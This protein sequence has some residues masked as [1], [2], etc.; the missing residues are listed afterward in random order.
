[1]KEI[2]K[3]RFLRDCIF[4]ICTKGFGM[5]RI[6]AFL[7][8]VFCLSLVAAESEADEHINVIIAIDES[9]SMDW[10]DPNGHRFTALQEFMYVGKA[11]GAFPIRIGV[12]PFAEDVFPGEAVLQPV[13]PA[14]IEVQSVVDKIKTGSKSMKR[15]WTHFPTAMKRAFR[16]FEAYPYDYN[17]LIVLSD[18]ID[19]CYCEKMYSEL[20]KNECGRYQEE[21]E[22]NN[23]LIPGT[24]LEEAI[25]FFRGNK[26][27]F[28]SVNINME[29][30]YAPGEAKLTAQKRKEMKVGRKL[31]ERISEETGGEFRP[32]GNP[33]VDA[34]GSLKAV[35]RIFEEFIGIIGSEENVPIE[36]VGMGDDNGFRIELKHGTVVAISPDLYYVQTADGNMFDVK[37]LQR[38]VTV[39]LDHVKATRHPLENQDEEIYI[40]NRPSNLSGEKNAQAENQWANSRGWKFLDRN[41]RAIPERLVQIKA[42]SNLKIKNLMRDDYKI[43]DCPVIKYDVSDVISPESVSESFWQEIRSRA[44]AKGAI[45]KS[46]EPP[47]QGDPA[48]L[49]LSFRNNEIYGQLGEFKQLGNYYAHVQLYLKG[50]NEIV[51]ASG[52]R[53]RL[54][55]ED[56]DQKVIV[57][58]VLLKDRRGR[59]TETPDSLR[60]VIPGENLEVRF[61]KPSGISNLK[62]DVKG[63]KVGKNNLKEISG[64]GKTQEGVID[65]QVEEKGE[66]LELKMEYERK[67]PD[68]EI[69]KGKATVFE[70][71]NRGGPSLLRM[72]MEWK[73]RSPVSLMVGEASRFELSVEMEGGLLADRQWVDTNPPSI[74]VESADGFE[75]GHCRYDKSEKAEGKALRYGLYVVGSC[76]EDLGPGSYRLVPN[77]DD[78]VM[79][80]IGMRGGFPPILDVTLEPPPFD[81]FFVL[82]EDGDGNKV[83]QRLPLAQDE[84]FETAGR[85]K[86]VLASK[87]ECGGSLPEALELFYG[88]AE[89]FFDTRLADRRERTDVLKFTK[90][91]GKNEW[92]TEPFGFKRAGN[93]QIGLAFKDETGRTRNVVLSGGF[94]TRTPPSCLARVLENEF[95]IGGGFTLPIELEIRGGVASDLPNV[96]SEIRTTLKSS[97]FSIQSEENFSRVI[98]SGSEPVF[99]KTENRFQIR[100]SE[101]PDKPGK[102]NLVV[103]FPEEGVLDWIAAFDIEDGKISFDYPEPPYWLIAA[104]GTLIV[105]LLLVLVHL[106]A[107]RDFPK[108][109]VRV[110]NPAKTDWHPLFPSFYKRMEG[111]VCI[112]G[113]TVIDI[114]Y[115]KQLRGIYKDGVKNIGQPDLVKKEGLKSVLRLNEKPELV[116]K[117]EKRFVVACLSIAI[118]LCVFAIGMFF[119]HCVIFPLMFALAALGLTI[120]VG[121]AIYQLPFSLATRKAFYPLGFLC[122]DIGSGQ[123]IDEGRLELAHGTPK[124]VNSISDRDRTKP[125]SSP[126]GKDMSA[127]P[128]GNARTRNGGTMDNACRQTC[129]WAKSD[130]ESLLTTAYRCRYQE[131]APEKSCAPPVE[132]GGGTWKIVAGYR[133][134]YNNPRIKTDSGNF[135]MQFR[136]SDDGEQSSQEKKSNQR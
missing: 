82:I 84:T 3:A 111:A 16:M 114:L 107:K 88:T 26:I 43:N 28:H 2:F 92:E 86:A 122:V 8:L 113:R 46:P 123:L 9:G 51:I 62:V 65:L 44:E 127:R 27:K 102:W 1:M 42:I 66:K 95:P 39:E 106:F 76:L 24:E 128:G 71:P 32:L 41:K 87:P 124:T 52:I 67:T 73:T 47:A 110:K 37:Q 94:V 60:D 131:R 99:S 118:A 78:R 89:K 85:Y 129:I 90:L 49:P 18:G 72:R 59:P 100:F 63:A 11:L 97:S 57:T 64:S 31:L 119:F 69:R 4:S 15:N 112:C 133:E 81:A 132:G 130:P 54:Q 70:I 68:G 50:Q 80:R 14:G 36:N 96:M 38:D 101:M 83:E 126:D 104:A 58:G 34:D 109:E 74:A 21:F 19:S 10:Q 91:T 7:C 125:D 33:Y 13:E 35:N 6:C 77:I 17:H 116:F 22:L 75:I 108:L 61:N 105:Y 117:R 12:L 121:I 136:Q 29:Y 25:G 79:S 115:R 45:G 20:V 5:K 55:V 56:T 103:R 30:G 48:W 40:F 93:V 53:D 23:A 135:T 120:F 98:K 134:Q